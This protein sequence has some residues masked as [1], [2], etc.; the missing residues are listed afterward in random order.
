[1]AAMKAAPLIC[2]QNSSQLVLPTLQPFLH[3]IMDFRSKKFEMYAHNP[4]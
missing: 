2:A 1:M 4:V 3:M